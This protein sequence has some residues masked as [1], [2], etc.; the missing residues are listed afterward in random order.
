MGLFLTLTAITLN[1]E[2]GE[3][4]V[5]ENYIHK[6]HPQGKPLTDSNLKV[7]LT[8]LISR[9]AA[10]SAKIAPCGS[11]QA[12]ESLNQM[13]ASKNPKSRHYAASESLSFRVQAAIC[14]KNIGCQYSRL[15]FS[16][17][18]YEESDRSSALR[19]QKDILRE[20]KC[21]PI[22]KTSTKQR[23]QVLKKLRASKNA[24]CD[25]KEGITYES[26]FAIDDVSS[27][28]PCPENRVEEKVD[29]DACKVLLYDLETTGTS[30]EDEIVQVS[31]Y[32][33]KIN[34]F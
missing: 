4:I 1:A 30:L 21:N 27:L 6:Y 13:I 7:R 2:I 24:A 14:Q 22:S 10:N 16:K 25:R 17:L 15:V 20:R 19:K 8:E 31:C 23:R 33:I 3:A 11:S 9:Y 5:N 29:L 18:N 26:G 34:L 32:I 12:N 28:I